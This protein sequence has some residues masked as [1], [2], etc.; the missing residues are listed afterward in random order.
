[1]RNA[2]LIGL[3]ALLWVACNE[4]APSNKPKAGYLPDSVG[5]TLEQGDAS[6]TSQTSSTPLSKNDAE[7]HATNDARIA[8]VFPDWKQGTLDQMDALPQYKTA[9]RTDIRRLLRNQPIA[10]SY[11]KAVYPRILYKAYKFAS[12]EALQAEVNTWLNSHQHE[13]GPIQLGKPVK[14]FK[15]VPLHC[16]MTATDLVVVQWSCV[17]AGTEWDG[18]VKR[19]YNAAREEMATLGWEVI[20]GTGEFYYQIQ[21]LN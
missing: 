14:S 8:K 19:F 4:T 7:F 17:Y 6:S 18:D 2:I 5:E 16:Y 1:M 3:T 21:S 15:S 20:C 12:T 13:G 11:G 9:L 10:N